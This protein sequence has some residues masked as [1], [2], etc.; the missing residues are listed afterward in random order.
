MNYRPFFLSGY[1][2]VFIV[3]SATLSSISWLLNLETKS[4]YRGVIA[5]DCESRC[6]GSLLA[7]HCEGLR[8]PLR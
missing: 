4:G 6:G 7:R 2:G 5:K 3:I 1:C 8:K